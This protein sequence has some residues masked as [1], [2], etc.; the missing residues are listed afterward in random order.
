MGCAGWC[1]SAGTVKGGAVQGGAR[2]VQG[3]CR[4]VQELCRGRACLLVSQR[5]AP[6]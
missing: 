1:S 6:G 4:A 3:L 5:L 2:A